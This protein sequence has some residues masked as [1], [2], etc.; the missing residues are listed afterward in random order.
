MS[1]IGFK[2]K[3]SEKSQK[4]FAENGE[5]QALSSGCHDAAVAYSINPQ[6]GGA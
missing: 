1:A 6:G 5:A 3:Q 2:Y 4:P